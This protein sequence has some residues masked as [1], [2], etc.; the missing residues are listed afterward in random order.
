MPEFKLNKLVRDKLP[1][2]YKRLDQVA[3]YK[4]LTLD[5]YKIELINKIIEEAKEIKI[6]GSIDSI[7]SEIADIQQALD[8]FVRLC[9][10]N[11][12]EISKIQQKKFDK[13]GGFRN[14]IYVKTIK[15]KD[16]DSWVQYYRDN[17]DTFPEV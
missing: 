5:E 8:D 15:L 16:D 7:K 10:I 1:A 4:V 17:P 12:D 9:G 3:K 6:D 14:S 2:D 11:L 13:K